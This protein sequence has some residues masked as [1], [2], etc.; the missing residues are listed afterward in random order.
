MQDKIDQLRTSPVAPQ[1]LFIGGAW[2]E[3]TGGAVIDVIS[4]I[5]GRKLTTIADAGAEDVDLA[6]QAARAVFEKGTWSKAA[7]A[8]RKKVLL[9]I[10]ELIEKNALDVAVLGVRDNGTEISMALKAEPGSAAATFR[11]YAETIDKIYGEIA[12]TAENVL[13]LVH[14]EPVGVVAAIVPWNFP[15][16]IGAWKIAPA[17]AAGN[18]VVLK[19]AEGASL[20]LLKL[21]ELCAAAGLPEGVLNVVTGRGSV[22]GEA[23]G[24]HR[25]IDVLAFTGSGSVGRRLLEYSARSNLKRVYLE[26]GGKSPNVVFADAPDLDLAARVSAHAIFRNSGQVCVAGSRLLVEKAISEEFSERVAKIAAS[27]KVGD[28]LQLATEAGAIASDIQL[29]KDLSYAGQALAEGA[30]LRTG[31]KRILEETGGYYMQPTVFDVSQGMT[32]AREE[33]FGPILSIIPFETESEAL[34][35]ANATEYGLA[36]AVWTANLSRA[37]RMVRGIRAGVVHVNTYGGADNTVP[38][39]GVRQSGNGHDK[40]LHAFD[41]YVDLKTAWI[42]L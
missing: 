28:P 42:Q 11:Y 19:P 31:G 34:Q 26:L 17:L 35:I 40:S 7:P 21:A 24:L 23:L 30:V 2:R 32:L 4:P 37:H 39:G 41:K 13:G 22:C 25:D 38:L 29:E 6:V 16:M 18:S 33:V 27:L 14:R 20:T 10:A 1:S 12:P 5:D 9:R 3:P 15:M 36:S 8:E